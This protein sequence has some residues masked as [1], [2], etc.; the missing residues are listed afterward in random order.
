M[1]GVFVAIFIP[2]SI[3]QKEITRAILGWNAGVFI[4]LLF[5]FRVMFWTDQENIQ[6][7]ARAQDEGRILILILVI[8]ASL[9]TLGAIFSELALSKNII[10][11]TR[12]LHM[13][14]AGLTILTS[15]LFT[16]VMFAQHYA[17]DYYLARDQ[18]QCGG[19]SFPST[20]KPDYL[21]FLYF[22]C[23]IGTSAQT[24]DVSFTSKAMRRT[25]LFH[26]VLA[27]FFNTT[28]LALTIN[29]ASGLF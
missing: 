21:D 1:I 22:S 17:H 3:V 15:W 8:F 28:L 24:A 9:A 18:G 13:A 5:T 4:Y 29:I 16:H 19:L 23:I 11:S 10:D 6:A 14:L 20:E 26:C 2:T 25:G 12:Y 7:R 27:F